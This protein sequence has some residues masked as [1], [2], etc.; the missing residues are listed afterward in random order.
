MESRYLSKD[1]VSIEGW[2]YERAHHPELVTE[3]LSDRI[4]ITNGETLVLALFILDQGIITQ[5][6][7]SINDNEI[8]VWA[9][10]TG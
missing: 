3:Q 6:W 7:K 2:S 5:H 9:D 8:S 10:R 1:N 4:I